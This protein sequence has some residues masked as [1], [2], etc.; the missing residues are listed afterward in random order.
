M[1]WTQLKNGV[2]WNCKSNK[3]VGLSSNRKDSINIRDDVRS[4]LCDQQYNFPSHST[5]I[6]NNSE[7]T[8]NDI[9]YDIICQPM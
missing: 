6:E 8:T 1:Q 9:A 4:L 5:R 3:M 2:C 7:D